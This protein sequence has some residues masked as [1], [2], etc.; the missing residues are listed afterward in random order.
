MKKSNQILKK[1]SFMLVLSVLFLT[2][3]VAMGNKMTET[4]ITGDVIKGDEPEDPYFFTMIALP[5]TQFYSQQYPEIFMTQTQWIVDNKDE[6]NIIYVTHE[7]DIVQ[8]YMAESQ[9][10]DA[11]EAMSLLEDP[12]T[13]GL[14]DGIN[15]SVLP[16]NHD[17]P[18]TLYNEYFGVSNFED[19][20]YYGGHYSTTNDNNYVLFEVGYLKFIALSLGYS[21]NEDVLNWADEILQSH[22]DRRAILTSHSII[23]GDGEW[24]NEGENI[25]EALKDNSN[26]FLMLCGHVHT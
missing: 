25:Y 20:D 17:L 14:P 21:P 23:D 22:S 11:K 5:D 1:A 13:T 2:S 8:D 9:W 15:Y 6:L 26:L 19:K 10:E 18:S 4:S 24:L 3:L 7:G 16:G 12:L